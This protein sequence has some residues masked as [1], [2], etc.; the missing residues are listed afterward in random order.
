MRSLNIYAT[1]RIRRIRRLANTQ[2]AKRQSFF[3]S[4]GAIIQPDLP[5][6]VIIDQKEC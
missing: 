4:T 6:K 1:L 5:D 2:K 3:Q